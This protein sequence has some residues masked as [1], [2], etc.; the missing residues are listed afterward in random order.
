MQI[1]VWK[2]KASHFSDRGDQSAM[3][4]QPTYSTPTRATRRQPAAA[5]AAATKATQQQQRQQQQQGQQQ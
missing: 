5:P 4:N 3:Q 2:D 1:G